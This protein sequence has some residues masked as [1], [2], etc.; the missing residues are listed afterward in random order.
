M[1]DFVDPRFT[2]RQLNLHMVNGYVHIHDLR[3]HCKQPLQ[4]IIKQIQ[5]QE[6][7]LQKWQDTTTADAGKTVTEEDI[8]HF[9]PGE[10]ERLFAEDDAANQG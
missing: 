7:T 3:C 6:P 4:H 2:K 9:G 8:D 1:S 5:E 10:L